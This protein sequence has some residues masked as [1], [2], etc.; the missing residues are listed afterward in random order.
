M[1]SV[2]QG[3]LQSWEA[4]GAGPKHN[5]FSTGLETEGQKKKKKKWATSQSLDILRTAPAHLSFMVKK[6]VYADKTQTSL[7]LIT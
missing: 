6:R 3:I 4:A 7:I 5:A 2:E 1:Q